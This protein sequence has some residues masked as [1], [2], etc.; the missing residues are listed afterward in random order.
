MVD[1]RVLIIVMAAVF[2]V[3]SVYLLTRSEEETDVLRPHA[4]SFSRSS[5]LTTFGSALPCVSFI[6]WPTRKPSTPS[7]PPR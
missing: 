3:G 6:T 1:Y 2:A 4:C 7:L 5:R